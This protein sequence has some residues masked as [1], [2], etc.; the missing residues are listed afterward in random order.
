MGNMKKITDEE[1]ENVSG[2]AIL[3]KGPSE[4][5]IIDD[6]TG[7]ILDGPFQSLSQ[8]VLFNDFKCF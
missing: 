6:K 1:L 2:G 8:A 4:Y 3:Q 5:Y 7:K